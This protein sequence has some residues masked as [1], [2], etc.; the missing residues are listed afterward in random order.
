MTPEKSVRHPHLLR[1]FWVGIIAFV[2]LQLYYVRETLPLLIIFGLFFSVG[3][4]ILFVLYLVGRAGEVSLAKAEPYA[5]SA[6]RAGRRG[7]GQVGE[8]SKKQFRRQH[9]ENV[10]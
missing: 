3:T 2:A 6:A 1:W 4:S 8:F 5:I 9:S 10:P 7:L